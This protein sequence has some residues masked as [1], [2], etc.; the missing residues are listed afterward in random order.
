MQPNFPFSKKT[1][2][3]IPSFKITNLILDENESRVPVEQIDGLTKMNT[4]TGAYASKEKSR[5]IDMF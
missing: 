4:V 5:K 2:K 3:P 1:G